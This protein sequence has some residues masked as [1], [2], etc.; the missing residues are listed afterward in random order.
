L[1]V[2]VV[3]VP[4]TPVVAAASFAAASFAVEAFAAASYLHV[5]RLV[6]ETASEVEVV[7]AFRVVGNFSEF[8]Y[9]LLREMTF[10]YF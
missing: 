10:I 8:L 5:G 4:D 9:R 6:E 7:E 2:A 1:R 3:V